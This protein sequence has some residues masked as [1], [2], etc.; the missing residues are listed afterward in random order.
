MGGENIMHQSTTLA[1]NSSCGE[2]INNKHDRHQSPVQKPQHD[3]TAHVQAKSPGE[4]G[5]GVSGVAVDHVGQWYQQGHILSYSNKD[6]QHVRI[7]KAPFNDCI[8]AGECCK[9]FGGMLQNIW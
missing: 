8:T 7:N 5:Q 9:S 2:T 3:M 6:R 4:I 1:H